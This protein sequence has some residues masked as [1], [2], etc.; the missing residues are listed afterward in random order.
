MPMTLLIIII[1]PRQCLCYCHHGRAIARVHLVYLMNVEQ[2]QA[3]ADL[4]SGPMI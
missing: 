1:I 2:C 4:R 3:A